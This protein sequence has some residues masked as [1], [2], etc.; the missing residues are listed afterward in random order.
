MSDLGLVD[1]GEDLPGR[2]SEIG[3]T[4]P[5]AI[6]WE[7]WLQVGATVQRIHKMSNWLVADWYLFGEQ[8][9]GEDAAAATNDYLDRGDES[10]RQAVWVAERFP[11]EKRQPKLSWT[12]HRIAAGVEAPL[13]YKLL[14]AAAATDPVMSTRDLQAYIDGMLLDAQPAEVT[15]PTEATAGGVAKVYDLTEEAIEAM[16]KHAEIQRP[17]DSTSFGQGWVEALRWTRHTEHFTH[18]RD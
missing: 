12:H 9:W 7:R 14:E 5:P 13:R 4:L 16:S 17:H 3:Y 11:L 18:W 8:A 6:T 15:E 1:H 10:L 2:L